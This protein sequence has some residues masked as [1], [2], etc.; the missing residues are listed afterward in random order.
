MN[1]KYIILEIIPTSSNPKFGDVV[2]L[3][4]LKIDN[5]KLIDRFDYRLV[6]DNI[7]F[8]EMREM[9]S[10]DKDKFE[11]RSSTSEIM[12]EFKEWIEDFQ[13]LILDNSYTRA[14]L[15]DFPNEKKDISLY[16]DMTYNDEIIDDIIEKY[17]LEP[18]NY[19]V[20]LLYEALIYESN[21]KRNA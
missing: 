18:S 6:E 21:N 15:D 7:P 3:S 20:D 8:S 14:Y 16:F 9:V 5:L 19:I 13:L 1:K 11:Y 10:Y 12:H 2:Q 17:N 4:A